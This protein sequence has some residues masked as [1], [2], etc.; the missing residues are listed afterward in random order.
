VRGRDWFLGEREA[1]NGWAEKGPSGRKVLLPQKKN[2]KHDKE[3]R[4]KRLLRERRQW[5]WL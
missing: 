4:K 3:I 1:G 5:R 2:D